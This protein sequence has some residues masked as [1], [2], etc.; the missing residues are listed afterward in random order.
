M[1]H[2]ILA[3][4]QA[5]VDVHE[6]LGVNDSLFEFGIRSA[7]LFVLKRRIEDFL[8]LRNVLAMGILLSSPT[9]GGIC[10][11]LEKCGQD[12]PRGYTPVVPL[13]RYT[14]CV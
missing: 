12:S 5:V 6:K 8:G 1:E 14:I 9:I 10:N 3:I 13:C 4:L 2:A 11:E 7:G